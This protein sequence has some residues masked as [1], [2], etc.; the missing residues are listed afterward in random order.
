[1][2]IKKILLIDDES[3]LLIAMKIRLVS[4]GYEVITAS[5]GKEGLELVKKYTPEAVILDIMMPD[6]D[7]LETLR[8]IRKSDK[9]L[10]VI[11]LTAYS[12]DDRIKMAAEYG[13]SGF[14]QKGTEPTDVSQAIR[15]MLERVKSS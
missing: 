3:E 12:N 9:T 11:M 10:P 4:W 6:M 1:M 15:V 2:P 7:G 14:I 8:R 13:I 5:N